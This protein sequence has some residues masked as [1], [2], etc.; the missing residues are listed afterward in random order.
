MRI[1]AIAIAAL[2]LTSG[3]GLAGQFPTKTAP[4][5]PRIPDLFD[6]NLRLLKPD[7]SALQSI[8]FLTTDDFPPFHFALADGT[9]AGFDIDL[10]RAI[11]ADL[12]IACT[13]QARRFDTLTAALKAGEADALI[14]AVANTPAAREQLAFTAPYYTTPG[15]FVIVTASKPTRDPT[16]V[17]FAGRTVGVEGGTAHEAFLKAF[18]SQVDHQAVPGSNGSARRAAVG[19][20]RCD[21]RRWSRACALVEQHR[22]QR[23]LRLRQRSFHREPILWQRRFDRRRHKGCRSTPTARPRIS[24]D[25]EVWYLCRS[26]SQILPG[27]VLLTGLSPTIGR[28]RA[29]A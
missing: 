8:R 25:G 28:R 20:R 7:V 27:R 11:C 29:I 19:W 24:R 5:K 16:A 18:F 6:P 22:R 1:A 15:R 26:L 14:A 4:A 12:K 10:A 23:M 2:L 17:M 21:L 13:I 3:G 9:L